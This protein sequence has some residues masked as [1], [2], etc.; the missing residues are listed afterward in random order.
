MV[1]LNTEP[2]IFDIEES[3]S[4]RYIDSAESKTTLLNG[5]FG[6]NKMRSLNQ[7]FFINEIKYYVFV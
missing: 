2:F 7:I 4:F 1:Y 6:K 3:G 5:M